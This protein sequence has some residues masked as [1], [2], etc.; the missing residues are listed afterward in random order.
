MVGRVV[1]WSRPPCD[2]F[3]DEAF[4]AGVWDFM[5][6]EE[7]RDEATLLF[8]QPPDVVQ[9]LE[10]LSRS[11]PGLNLSL[12]G[13]GP[14]GLPV[15]AGTRDVHKDACSGPLIV[16]CWQPRSGCVRPACPRREA[17]TCEMELKKHAQSQPQA[18]RLGRPPGGRFKGRW[19]PCNPLGV[20]VSKHHPLFPR[21][22]LSRQLLRGQCKLH[23]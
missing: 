8:E 4:E 1:Q 2:W 12:K 3:S 22:T 18:G 6:G 23:F 15:W 16:S 17:S 13:L 14:P 9:R 11:S 21:Q 5:N 10:D 19:A 20:L 7:G